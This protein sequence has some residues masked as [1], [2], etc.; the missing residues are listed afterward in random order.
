MPNEMS[1][2]EYNNV[3]YEIE[4]EKARQDLAE[5][6]NNGYYDSNAKKI[7]LRHG[8]DVIVQIDAT[9]FIK[10]GMVSNVQIINGYLVITFNTDS[11]QEPISIPITD[12]FNP[13]NYYTKSA[14]NEL[15]SLKQDVIQDLAQIRQG[16][17]A[18]A[19]A[20]QKPQGGI[21]KTD[22]SDDVKE[23]LNKA[24][25]AAPKKEVEDHYARKDGYYETLAAGTANNLKSDI[26]TDREIM[27]DKSGG[28]NDIDS[29][30]ANLSRVQGNTIAW[31]QLGNGIMVTGS[32]AEISGKT[33][34][35]FTSTAQAS[36][37]E[38]QVL[39]RDVFTKINH[40]YYYA[41][42]YTSTLA[43]KVQDMNQGGLVYDATSSFVHV[44]KI[45]VRE[46]STSYIPMYWYLYTTTS[47]TWTLVVKNYVVVDLTG[48]Y[49]AGNEPT[50]VAQFEADYQQWFGKPLTYEPYVA[51]SLR[52]VMMSAIKTTGFNQW[53]E[54]WEVGGIDRE[55]GNNTTRNDC[56]RTKN[57]IKIFKGLQYYIRNIRY[58]SNANIYI[59][60]Y[61]AN[62]NF[63]E[64]S[65]AITTSRNIPIK[66]NAE[67]IRFYY[68]AVTTYHN[69]ICI[70]ISDPDKNGTYEPYRENIAP[71]PITTLTGKLNGEGE[72]VTIFPDGMK[73]AGSVRDEIFVEN[74]VVKAI[75]RVGSVD[76]GSLYYS[77]YGTKVRYTEISDIK[78]SARKIGNLRS[79]FYTPVSSGMEVLQIPE[80]MMELYPNTK[81]I[82][83]MDS[84]YTN[85]QDFKAAVN[86]MPLYYELAEPQVYVLDDDVLPLM[87]KVDE[88]GTEQVLPECTEETPCC[89]PILSV[90]YAMNAVAQLR[91]MHTNYISK[92][93]FDNF[94][95]L[96]N[97]TLVSV[98]GGTISVNPTQTNDAYTFAFSEVSNMVVFVSNG[99]Q[100]TDVIG[101]FPPDSYINNGKAKFYL[102]HDNALI[103]LSVAYTGSIT[104]VGVYSPYGSN[105]TYTVRF[106]GAYSTSIIG[107]TVNVEQIN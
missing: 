61:D 2:F 5:C 27:F 45:G 40:V 7:I 97:S 70:N 75:K 102:R 93:S 92:A 36:S 88:L 78:A 94:L 3:T 43:F 52:N 86:G 32:H 26:T 60:Y 83:I 65:N 48:I 42:D 25:G 15:L 28:L 89:A 62:K 29:G 67:Y 66:N 85:A 17:E 81:Y 106:S 100:I 38:K 22:M 39:Q 16:A 12:I 18:G 59:L 50:S 103:P 6:V 74:G 34:N 72:S 105:D 96:V 54:E 49:G 68:Y 41:F 77:E 99:S 84:R 98:L 87:Y 19:T 23:S 104:A 71:L 64:S 46:V 8:S 69:D 91:N 80:Y 21:P 47:Q 4:D 11:G 57:Y 14:T 90:N 73:S 56:I 33:S 44:S 95:S 63:L 20:Y 9:D 76:M 31:N 24:D 107:A 101:N 82:Y 55:T 13:D 79:T 58:N 35:G 10:D 51:G 37:E 1:F 30:S 53:D